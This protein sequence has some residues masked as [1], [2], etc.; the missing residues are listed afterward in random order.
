MQIRFSGCGSLVK[1]L[2]YH[3]SVSESLWAETSCLLSLCPYNQHSVVRQAKSSTTLA[4]IRNGGKLETQSSP[5][6]I[7]ILKASEHILPVPAWGLSPAA[8]L[9]A[10]LPL[11]FLDPLSVLLVVSSNSDILFKRKKLSLEL[12]CL[13]ILLLTRKQLGVQKLPFL[14]QSLCSFWCKLVVLLPEQFS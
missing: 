5:C 2:N 8:L 13:L 1:P 6:F 10:V 12:S 9:P 3:S 4:L 7:A 11:C 14:L